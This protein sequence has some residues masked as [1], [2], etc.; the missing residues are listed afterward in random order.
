MNHVFELFINLKTKRKWHEESFEIITYFVKN[1]QVQNLS[2][3]VYS[4]FLF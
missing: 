2:H 1:L 4:P 3:I